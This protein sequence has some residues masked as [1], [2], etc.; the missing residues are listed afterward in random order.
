MTQKIQAGRPSIGVTST[1]AYDALD[2]N[3]QSGCF[4]PAERPE[5]CSSRGASALSLDRF[6][7]GIGRSA[8]DFSRCGAVQIRL[9]WRKALFLMAPLGHQIKWTVVSSRLGSA[10]NFMAAMPG[11]V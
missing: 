3:R 8:L 5:I 4:I 9:P 2:S 1:R 11:K 7:R 10:A 6:F